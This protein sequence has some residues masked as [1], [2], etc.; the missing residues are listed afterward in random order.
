MAKRYDLYLMPLLPVVWYL[1]F[2]YGP[3]YGPQIA[4]KNFNPAKGILGADWEGFGHFER[5]FDSYYF[6][7]SLW[8]T[9]SINLFS[10]LIAFP[11]PILLALIINEIRE[12]LQQM[13]AE[14]YVHTAFYFGGRDRWH[15]KRVPFAQ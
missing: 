5:F 11:I 9:L 6:W 14:H 12:D 3:L 4:F 10:L 13:V 15:S 2:H 8:N 7:R 1:V